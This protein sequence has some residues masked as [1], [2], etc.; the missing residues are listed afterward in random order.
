M[1]KRKSIEYALK[2][3]GEEIL[4]DNESRN[5][6]T[7]FVEYRK[8]GS[9]FKSPL[10]EI[11][12]CFE[13]A[14]EILNGEKDLEVNRADLD[15]LCYTEYWEDYLT[16]AIDD[17]TTDDFFHDLI[18]ESAIRLENNEEYTLFKDELMKKLKLN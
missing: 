10:Q 12:E 11:V 1:F 3:N 9:N 15:D 13:L 18:R 2:S 14:Q 6:L 16:K 7:K 17:G 8:C 4:R 5:I